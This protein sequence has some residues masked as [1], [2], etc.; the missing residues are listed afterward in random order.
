MTRQECVG[1]GTKAELAQCPRCGSDACAD[2]LRD[3]ACHPCR[4]GGDAIVVVGG[5][6][7]T[8]LPAAQARPVAAALGGAVLM[9]AP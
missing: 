5:K 6:A 3:D 1:C 8:L 9:V 2:C 7:W 4:D